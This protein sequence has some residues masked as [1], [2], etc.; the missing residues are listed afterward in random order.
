[1]IRTS[2]IRNH[3]YSRN[4]TNRN[5]FFWKK[6]FHPRHC[7]ARLRKLVRDMGSH[8]QLPRS[9]RVDLYSAVREIVERSWPS[10][11]TLELALCKEVG[12]GR[13][14]GYQ[15]DTASVNSVVVVIGALIRCSIG[16]LGKSEPHPSREKT[17]LTNSSMRKYP[18]SI[19][20]WR[21]NLLCSCGS[22]YNNFSG[23]RAHQPTR[24]C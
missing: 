17:P 23:W 1:L 22:H 16:F 24:S 8:L 13:I 15:A 3:L 4:I 2:K 6:G 7:G 9:E 12:D 11:R 20:K 14:A 18:I 5:S 10:G 21:Y 19:Q